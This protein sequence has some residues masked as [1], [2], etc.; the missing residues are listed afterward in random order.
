MSLCGVERTPFTMRVPTR[1]T[2]PFRLSERT[3]VSTSVDPLS[4][5]ASSAAHSSSPAFSDCSVSLSCT[6]SQSSSRC[7]D[8]V[9]SRAS[10]AA[11]MG[12][13]TAV[14]MAAGDGRRS[15]GRSSDCCSAVPRRSPGRVAISY[16]QFE[17][18][19]PVMHSLCCS[20]S[21]AAQGAQGPRPSVLAKPPCLQPIALHSLERRDCS[22]SAN[23]KSQVRASRP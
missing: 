17:S 23:I 8:T 11:S 15:S 5:G 1:V 6:S 14:D 19:M 7:C 12:G 2:S 22:S 18:L 10:C 21:K 20:R 3:E 9:C 4:L 16:A 13:H